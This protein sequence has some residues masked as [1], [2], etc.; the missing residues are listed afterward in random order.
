MVRRQ[1]VGRDPA[2]RRE[3]AGRG[4]LVEQVV[5]EEAVLEVQK[6]ASFSQLFLRLARACLGKLIAF[7]K[8][9]KVF[10]TL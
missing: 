2:E 6:N 9:Q 1:V 5:A 3:S 4:L 8:L 7:I 10:R